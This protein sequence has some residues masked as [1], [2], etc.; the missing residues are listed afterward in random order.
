MRKTVCG[1]LSIVAC[2]TLVA[3]VWLMRKAPLFAGASNYTLYLGTSSAGQ[4]VTSS[5]AKDK[6]CYSVR[7]ESGEYEG[8]CYEQLKNKFQAKLLLS[9]EACGVKNYYLYSPKLGKT[10]KI[11]GKNVNLHV[12]V[13]EN[14]TA[15]GTPIIFGGY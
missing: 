3:A 7:G 11:G 4:I 10:I 6:L 8:D 5:P 2:F 1:V 9:E 15:V 13:K 14:T 12:A